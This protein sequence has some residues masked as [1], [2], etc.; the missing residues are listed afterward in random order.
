MA[1]VKAYTIGHSSR[2]IDEFVERLDEHAIRR[3]VDVRRY[4]GSRQHPQFN[5]EMLAQSLADRG[6]TYRHAPELG[7]RRR[8]GTD[9]VNTAWRNS[10]F[11]GYADW[12]ASPEFRLELDRLAGEVAKEATAVMC[13]EAMPWQCHRFLLADALVARDIEVVHI[14]GAD[15]V[16][17]HEL[18]PDARIDAQGV[19]TYPSDD[20]QIGLL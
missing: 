1:G 19:L 17:L 13:A 8:S 5:R 6:I 3:L 14:L 7:G 4:P 12:M 18:N 10:G 9:S 20:P 2:S 11:R 15:S 16:K